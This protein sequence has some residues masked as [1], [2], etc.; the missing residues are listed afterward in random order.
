MRRLLFLLLLVTPAYAGDRLRLAQYTTELTRD[1]PGLLYRDLLKPGA[2]GVETAVRRIVAAGADVLLLCGIDWDHDGLALDA[3]ADR[4]RAAG[5]DY[6]HR[7][8]LRPNTGMATGLDLDGDG[9]L[10]GPADAQGFGNFSGEKGMA[11]LSRL[12][13][14]REEIVDHSAM[15]W[16]DFPGNL[17]PLTGPAAAAQRLSTTGHWQV[18][19]LWG[20]GRVTL[21]T[22]CAGPPAFGGET[23]LRRNHD[24]TAIWGAL[25]DGRL[26]PPPSAPFVLMGDANLDPEGGD[27]MR[28]GMA[29]LLADPR[30]TDPR[31]ADPEGGRATADWTV[32]R[33]GKP[34]PGRLRV[35]YV[36]PSRDL[37][38]LSAALLPPEGEDRHAVVVLDVVLPSSRVEAAHAT[39]PQ[40][41]GDP[42]P[43]PQAERATARGPGSDVPTPPAETA[44]GMR[45]EPV[46]RESA[47]PF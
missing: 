21:L 4:V 1:G 9:R 27:G 23:S 36:L 37:T 44:G 24:E 6:P 22:W 8:A 42:L 29:R 28:Q 39:V 5:L 10:G 18:P 40:H 32:L 31:P 25:L 26:G 20:T 46:R 7:L 11:L 38:L 15:L 3:L 45:D 17:S 33:S 13:I 19:L 14:A 43:S 30:L 35:D 41:S 16:R 2:P 47:A 12:P 34:G